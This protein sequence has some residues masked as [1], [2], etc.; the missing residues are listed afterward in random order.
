MT[1]AERNALGVEKYGQN[2]TFDYTTTNRLSSNFAAQASI[3]AKQ[4]YNTQ[5]LS[6]QYRSEL[7]AKSFDGK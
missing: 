5:T 4:S 2:K 3:Q 1:K 6:S 7:T